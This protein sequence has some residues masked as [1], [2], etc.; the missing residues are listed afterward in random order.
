MK[1]HYELQYR[2]HRNSPAMK[3]AMEASYSTIGY[4]VKQMI[5]DLGIAHL[6]MRKMGGKWEYRPR[7]DGKWLD[8][9]RITV[10]RLY[11]SREMGE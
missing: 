10:R 3:Q 2:A 8:Y 7:V 1:E 6:G 4:R 5:Y 9:P 11:T